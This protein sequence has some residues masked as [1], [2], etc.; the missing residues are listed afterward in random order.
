[1]TVSVEIVVSIIGGLI[2][3]I[4]GYVSWAIDRKFNEFR[5]KEVQGRLDKFNEFQANTREQIAELKLK[6]TELEKRGKLWLPWTLLTSAQ[7]NKL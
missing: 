2:A 6:L 4:A 1:M 5:V 7:Q 3:F